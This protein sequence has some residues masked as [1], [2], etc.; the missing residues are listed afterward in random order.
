MTTGDDP[1][2]SIDGITRTF[3]AT[4][5]IVVL[6]GVSMTV[7]AGE[8]VV[9]FGRSGA[10]KSTLLNILGLLDRP[11]SGSY[12]LLGRDVS[13]LR[14]AARDRLRAD[15]LGFVFQAHHVIG[16]RTVAENLDLKLSIVGMPRAERATRVERVLDDLGLGDRTQAAG[17]TLSGGEKQRLA[18][19]RAVLTEPAVV[20]ADEPTGNLDDGNT[21]D[22]LSLF[23]VQAARGAAVVVITHD[24]RA[25][26]WAD[27]ALSLVGGRVVEGVA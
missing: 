25:A 14:G 2:I 23:D 15:A 26:E 4:Q 18:I 20:L 16:H 27:R 1:V 22:V 12:R 10:G 21:A 5:S 9:V 24:R 19:A 3:V 7:A 6:D 17:A 13:A 8:R 11:S